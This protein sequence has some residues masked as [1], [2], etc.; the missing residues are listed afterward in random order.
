MNWAKRSNYLT[1][2]TDKKKLPLNNWKPIEG[3]NSEIIYDFEAQANIYSVTCFYKDLHKIIIWYHVNEKTHIDTGAVLEKTLAINGLTMKAYEKELGGQIDSIEVKELTIKDFRKTFENPKR[4]VI[5]FNSNYYDLAVVSYILAKIYSQKTLPSTAEIRQ[6]NN[7]LINPIDTIRNDIEFSREFYKRHIDIK[8]RMS[9]Y[10]IASLFDNPS[11]YEHFDSMFYN[12]YKRTVPN[13][14]MIYKRLQDTGLH[15]DMKLLNEKDK[16]SSTM[17]TSLK[18]ISAQLGFQIEEPET[19]DLSSDKPITDEQCV[20]LLAYNASDVLVTTLIYETKAYQ[21]VLTTR[22]GLLNRFDATNFKGRLNVN[23]TSAKF[24]ENVIAPFDIDKLVD[25]YEINFFYPV[26]GKA[27]DALQELIN[28]DYVGKEVPYISPYKKRTLFIKWLQECKIATNPSIEEV[29]KLEAIHKDTFLHDYYKSNLYDRDYLDQ[30]W[31]DY[32]QTLPDF[33]P[34]KDENGVTHQRYR[35]KY[36]EIQEDLLEHARIKFPLFPKEVYLMY[37]YFRNAKSEYGT[38]GNRKHVLLKTGREVAVENFVKDY[39]VPPRN[40]YYKKKNNKVI[41]IKVNIQVP[42]Q[43][44]VLTF[45]VGGVHGEVIKKEAFERDSAVIDTYNY[46]LNEIKNTYENATDFY[47][48]YKQQTLDKHIAS[49]LNLDDETFSN[50]ITVFITKKKKNVYKYKQSKKIVNPKDYVIPIDMH[51]AVHVDV[52]SLYPSLMINLHMFSTWVS[53]Y[54]DPK[55]F[56]KT[57]KSGHW[58]DVYAKLRLERINLKKFALETPKEN[59]GPEQMH[60]WEIQLIN[61]LLLNSASGIADGKRETKV[62]VNNRAASMRIMG[63]LALTYLVYSVV[64]KGVYSTSTNTDGV[65]LTSDKPGFNE[66]SIDKEIEHWKTR[67]HLGATPEIMKHF[68]SKDSNNRFEQESLKEAGAPAGG[69]IGNA[70]GASSS[71]KMS[72]PFIIDAGIVNYFKTHNNVCTTKRSDIDIESIRE[73]LKAQQKIIVNAKEYT[74][75][76]RKAML[77]FCWPIQPKK[78]QDLVLKL[79]NSPIATYLP[80]QHVNRLLLVNN[81]LLIGGFKVANSGS[82]KTLNK[83]LTKWAQKNKIIEVNNIKTHAFNTKISNFENDWQ[84]VRVNLD[85]K[86]YFN[87]PVWNDLDIEA[88]AQLTKSKITGD[89][90]KEIWIEP[91]F[92]PLNIADK[93]QRVVKKS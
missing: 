38:V 19:V 4:Y 64:P 61:K 76:V 69:T 84:V 45:S 68:I 6:F 1:N 18:R 42:H 32:L 78:G 36:G 26:H 52:D 58:K 81:G 79:P 9:L 53:E 5:G 25:Q 15:L 8:K 34:V 11:P 43:P 28:K 91:D 14:Y 63:Q 87:S 73:Y 2:W 46:V 44:M 83:R 24:V 10:Y 92:K 80:M 20:N 77:S 31:T 55:A 59:W 89:V 75:E 7:L 62:R 72:Q 90:G 51:N 13:I 54:N 30:K 74:A 21:N 56:S 29:H 35:V 67:H 39:P 66:K 37:S 48:A 85:L 71:K 47:N 12:S 3:I 33:A 88:Y 50:D 57:N 82:Q 86:A 40:F 65:Y 70:F 49:L 41:G 17:Y 16:D 60:A 23:S 93:L 22:E 27:Y